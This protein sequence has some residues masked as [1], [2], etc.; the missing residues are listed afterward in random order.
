[1]Y[2]CELKVL[3]QS[4]LC[5]DFLAIR[6]RRRS[7]IR[8]DNLTNLNLTESV[9]FVNSSKQYEHVFPS[10]SFALHSRSRREATLILRSA[11]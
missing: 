1:M 7:A 4:G 3:Q 6:K 10:E 11:S 2:S 9:I 8:S 5:L